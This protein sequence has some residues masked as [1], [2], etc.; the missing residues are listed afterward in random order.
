M[1]HSIHSRGFTLVE[2]LVVLGIF[3]GIMVVISSFALN[4]SSNELFYTES[5]NSELEIR[6]ADKIIIS[7]L[8]SM[9]VSMA[10]SYPIGAAS[11]SSFTFFSDADNDG[12]TEQIRYFVEAGIL[13][14]GVIVPSGNPLS[15]LPGNEKIIESVHYL[16]SNNVFSYFGSNFDGS[17]SPLGYPMNAASIKVVKLELS[18]DKDPNKLPAKVTLPLYVDLR[19]LRG[20]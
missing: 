17:Q 13:K 1:Y 20:I 5:V 12:Y 7:E 11:S 15:Y 9:N 2:I 3:V 4:I 6:L 18:V 19:N 10:G 16:T 14:K 8:R